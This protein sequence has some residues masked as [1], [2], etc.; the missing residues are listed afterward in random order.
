V[1]TSNSGKSRVFA[2]HFSWVRPHV[3]CDPN[4]APLLKIAA[5]PFIA[6]L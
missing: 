4:Q 5:T 3:L 6:V 1:A 2:S